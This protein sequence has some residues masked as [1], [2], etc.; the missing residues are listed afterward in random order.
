MLTQAA[1]GTELLPF[2]VR[3]VAGTSFEVEIKGR[4]QT[5]QGYYRKRWDN[6]DSAHGVEGVES[7]M[8]NISKDKKAE[9]VFPRE[10]D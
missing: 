9:M 3:N 2:A 8:R 5:H 4:G 10:Y 7:K 6:A 1:P